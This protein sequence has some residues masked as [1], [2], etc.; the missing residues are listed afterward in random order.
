LPYLRVCDPET[1]KA[2]LRFARGIGEMLDARKV[3]PSWPACG[4]SLI[5]YHEDRGAALSPHR[6][7]E[8]KVNL[9]VRGSAKYLLGDRRY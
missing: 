5:V 2:P 7:D 4:P 6:H 1:A 3:K 8:L 9:V